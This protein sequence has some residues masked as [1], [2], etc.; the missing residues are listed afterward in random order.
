M[1]IETD[2]EVM[3][4]MSILYMTETT[5]DMIVTTMARNGNKNDATISMSL[6]TDIFSSTAG[7][8]KR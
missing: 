3:V 8:K 6:M 7:I 4:T 2:T 1:N 5:I